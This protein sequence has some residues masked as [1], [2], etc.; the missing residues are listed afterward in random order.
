MSTRL[1]LTIFAALALVLTACGTGQEAMTDAAPDDGTDVTTDVTTDDDADDLTDEAD[2]PVVSD[3]I[4]TTTP[5]A[6]E[7]VVRAVDATLAEGTATFDATVDIDTPELT[8]TITSNGVIDFDGQER[9]L[10]VAADQVTV[11]SLARPDGLLLTFDEQVG[12]V[13]VDPRQLRGTPLE[14]YGVASLP[15][16]DPSVNLQLLRGVTDDVQAHGETELEGEN[17]QHYDVIVD[18]E[19]AAAQADPDARAAVSDI[20]EQTGSTT[21]AMEVWIDA[22]DRIR[23]IAHTVDLSQADVFAAEATAG[24]TI[25]ITIDLYDFGEPVEISGPA[26]GEI[27]D[28]D[29]QTLEELIRRFTAAQ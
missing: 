6:A 29:E 10:D 3:D 16:Q 27:L 26:E 2:D 13:R 21:V 24:G 4:D 11:T 23:R 1:L 22:D 12:W 20:A 25:D 19:R 8:D 14:A 7:P 5:E 9:Q 17:V 15:L 28:V 18:V